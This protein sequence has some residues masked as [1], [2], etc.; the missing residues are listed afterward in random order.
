[1]KPNQ[2]PQSE[3][4]AICVWVE[5][6]IIYLELFDGRILGFPADRFRILASAS[7]EDLRKVQLELNGFALR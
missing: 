6:R 4:A 2:F 5:K 7:G 1:L 3:P